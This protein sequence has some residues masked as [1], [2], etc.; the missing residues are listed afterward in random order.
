MVPASVN[1]KY[2]IRFC[3]VAQNA[4]EDDIGMTC[5]SRILPPIEHRLS[6]SFRQ[7]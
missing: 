1:E 5:L 2:I 6:L 7:P 3:A 4:N